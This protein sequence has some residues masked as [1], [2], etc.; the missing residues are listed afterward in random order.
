[1]DRSRREARIERRRAEQRRSQMT[2]LGII[3]V[4]AVAVTGLLIYGNRVRPP[5]RTPG[6][7]GYTQKNGISLGDPAAPVTFIE[8]AD[9]QCPVC[10]TWYDTVE[11]Q[12]IDTYVNSGDVYYTYQVVG[13]LDSPNLGSNES[14]QSAEAAY[15]AADQNKFWE[16]HDVLFANQAGENLGAFSDNRLI[17][18]AESINLNMDTFRSC[19]LNDEKAELVTQTET[20]VNSL[21]INATPSFVINGKVMQGL[22]SF[23]QIQAEIEAALAAA[24]AN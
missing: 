9:F 8:V 22:Q 23:P 16:Y 5:Q 1:M 24:G 17:A 7:A 4:V 6:E 20:A 19:F 13:F 11:A 3:V 15:C 21:G 14:T 18:F 10:K 2:W 12:V